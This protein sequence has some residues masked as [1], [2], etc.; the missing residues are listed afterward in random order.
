MYTIHHADGDI[1]EPS[2][3]AAMTTIME[4]FAHDL[5]LLREDNPGHD[6]HVTYH[7][8]LTHPDG[9]EALIPCTTHDFK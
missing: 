8:L 4:L 3:P 9:R 1:I 6:P 7:Y 2:L 5:D